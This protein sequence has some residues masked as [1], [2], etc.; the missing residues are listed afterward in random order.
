MWVESPRFLRSHPS[1]VDVYLEIHEANWTVVGPE[2]ASAVAD[3]GVSGPLHHFQHCRHLRVSWKKWSRAAFNM[4]WCIYRCRKLWTIFMHVTLAPSG[5]QGSWEDSQLNPLLIIYPLLPLSDDP[6]FGFD[7]SWTSLRVLFVG[8][9]HLVRSSSDTVSAF[10][11]FVSL[12]W[13]QGNKVQDLVPIAFLIS[14]FRFP[15]IIMLLHV[16]PLEFVSVF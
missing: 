16:K 4:L 15:T 14:L 8:D 6:S 2:S 9:S 11:H 13:G 10:D 7:M 3:N 12:T 1:T 5:P